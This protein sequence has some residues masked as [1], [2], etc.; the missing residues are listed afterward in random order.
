MSQND[1]LIRRCPAH[2]APLD[3]EGKCFWCETAEGRVPVVTWS[4]NTD[5]RRMLHAMKIDPEGQTPPSEG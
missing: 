1:P 3:E 5:D 2:F 4:L